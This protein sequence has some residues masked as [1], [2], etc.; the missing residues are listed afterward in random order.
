MVLAACGLWSACVGRQWRQ[1][2]EEML[3]HAE[4]ILHFHHTSS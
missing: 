2:L 1:D 3:V 4:G